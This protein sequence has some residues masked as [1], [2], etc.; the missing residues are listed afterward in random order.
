MKKAIENFNA[1]EKKAIQ[2]PYGSLF[3]DL[4]VEQGGDDGIEWMMLY[5][6]D[7][8]TIMRRTR[9]LYAKVIILTPEGRKK[10]EKGQ[11]KIL[12]KCNLHKF[13]TAEFCKA[14]AIAMSL[15]DA[16]H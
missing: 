16:E 2:L 10:A 7:P 11:S 14:L 8:C 6:D 3:A 12:M 13:E 1:P 4:R 5:E 9:L 15:W